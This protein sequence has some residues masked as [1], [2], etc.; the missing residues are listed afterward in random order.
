MAKAAALSHG[1]PA[2]IALL[3]TKLGSESVLCPFF[4]NCDGILLVNA[5]GADQFHPS[6][7]C[8]AKEV[9]D[10]I[11]ELK[12]RWLVCGFIGEAEKRRLGAAGIEVRLGSCHCSAGELVAAFSRLPKA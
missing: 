12:P 8:G 3:V 1:V 7:C 11:L 4:G 6:G 5:D 2:V 10:R 9:C